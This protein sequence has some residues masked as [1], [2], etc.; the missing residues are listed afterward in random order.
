MLAS[1]GIV[2]RGNL[3]ALNQSVSSQVAALLR[4]SDKAVQRTALSG[5]D[6][7]RVLCAPGHWQAPAASAAE[8]PLQQAVEAGVAT[9][10]APTGAV[11]PNNETFDDTEFYAQLLKEFLEATGSAGPGL[12]HTAQVPTRSAWAQATIQQLQHWGAWAVWTS[13]QLQGIN[14][15][16]WAGL[17]HCFQRGSVAQHNALRDH[18]CLGEYCS[19]A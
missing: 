3:R 1:G 6:R 16:A 12:V 5:T 4:S 2:S 17:V 9:A 15:I 14:S 11:E 18:S 7:P 8:Q 10:T 19:S 13:G